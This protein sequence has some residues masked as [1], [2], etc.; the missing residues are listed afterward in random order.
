MDRVNAGLGVGLPRPSHQEEPQWKNEQL[1][2][3][4]P[5]GPKVAP[6]LESLERHSEPILKRLEEVIG[7]VAVDTEITKQGRLWGERFSRNPAFMRDEV[8]Y[9]TPAL[10]FAV[11]APCPFQVVNARGN[12]R[13]ERARRLRK[14]AA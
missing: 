5:F 12:A 3:R 13:G 2:Q 14:Q 7:V 11:Q 9:L 10:L 1:V 8:P 6:D 4:P